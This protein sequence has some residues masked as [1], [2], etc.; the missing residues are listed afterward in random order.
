M[1]FSI[2]LSNKENGRASVSSTQAEI[3]SLGDGNA[4]HTSGE[5]DLMDQDEHL[6]NL[7]SR[8]LKR[9]KPLTTK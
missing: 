9:F 7:V 8:Q 5:D 2:Q 4:G 3:G 6:A 1:H